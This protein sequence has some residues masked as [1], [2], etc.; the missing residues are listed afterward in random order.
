M[1]FTNNQSIKVNFKLFVP[2][3]AGKLLHYL[4]G[5]SAETVRRFRPHSFDLQTIQVLYRE[6]SKQ[7]AY[8]A[9]VPESQEYA[10]YFALK[11]GIIPHDEFRFSTYGIRSEQANLCTFAP[12]V[13]DSW[14]GN[15]LGSAL[16]RF[17]L[18]QLK[19]Y[20]FR[21][22][23]LWGGVQADNYRALAYY[24]KLGFRQLGSF[25]HYGMNHD[26]LL[27]L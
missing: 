25:E 13:A 16:F 4:Q 19:D 1:I 9:E 3:E 23:V 22:M 20:G 15:G 24:H 5:L 21:K 11:T 18:P 14:Q 12:S 6:P 7:L 2:E 26:M 8:V 27:E 10:A 17:M